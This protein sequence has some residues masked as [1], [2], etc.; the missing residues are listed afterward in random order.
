MDLIPPATQWSRA[1][2]PAT[3]VAGYYMAPIAMLRVLQDAKQVH[4]ESSK[5]KSY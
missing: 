1:P 5:E 4:W 2:L 3:E